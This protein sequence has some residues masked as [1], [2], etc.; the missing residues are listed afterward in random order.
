MEV[1][2]RGSRKCIP[3]NGLEDDRT[4]CGMMDFMQAPHCMPIGFP[5]H[6]PRACAIFPRR[7]TVFVYTSG[8][9][10]ACRLIGR[11][12]RG[13]V[14]R[15]SRRWETGVL[16]IYLLH[17]L[18]EQHRIVISLNTEILTKPSP[19]FLTSYRKHKLT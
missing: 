5:C 15:I 12:K 1:T 4:F 9:A 16:I 8:S 2:G 7:R 14:V 10:V 19:L 3:R 18:G 11:E 13:R 6:T 17:I